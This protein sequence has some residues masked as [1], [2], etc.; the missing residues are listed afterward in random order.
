MR[1]VDIDQ[2]SYK[3]WTVTLTEGS[4]GMSNV[5]SMSL[6]IG[7]PGSS[8]FERQFVRVKYKNGR[9][10]LIYDFDEVYLKPGEVY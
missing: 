8:T 6:A 1:Y 10:K 5:E 7:E 9:T 4:K 3:Q 2:V